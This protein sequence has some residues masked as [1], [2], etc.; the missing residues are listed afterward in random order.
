MDGNGKRKPSKHKSGH[1]CN[2]RQGKA[3]ERRI[4]FESNVNRE[5]AIENHQQPG[6]WLMCNC[7]LIMIK[8]FEGVWFL[9]DNDYCCYYHHRFR[10]ISI[11]FY[12]ILWCCVCLFRLCAAFNTCILFRCALIYD[13]FISSIFIFLLFGPC[14]CVRNSESSHES[15]NIIVILS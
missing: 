8:P 14:V 5:A 11:P 15:Y 13:L 6:W 7:V 2:A 1:Q 3:T 10:I 9:H 12:F 4:T